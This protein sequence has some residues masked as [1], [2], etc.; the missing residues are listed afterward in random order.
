MSK[1]PI[2]CHSENDHASSS[3]NDQLIQPVL[4]ASIGK[5][6]SGV[7]VSLEVLQ[8]EVLDSAVQDLPKVLAT[9]YVQTDK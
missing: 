4:D 5:P 7:K 1:S 8:L 3:R 2:T 6:A 9:G